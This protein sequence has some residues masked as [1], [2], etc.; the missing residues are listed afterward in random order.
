MTIHEITRVC[1]TDNMEGMRRILQDIS[2]KDLIELKR[3]NSFFSTV[4]IKKWLYSL[5]P[6]RV[7]RSE[8]RVKVDS[9]RDNM[10]NLI[11]WCWIEYNGWKYKCKNANIHLTEIRRLETRKDKLWRHEHRDDMQYYK[12]VSALHRRAF[13]KKRKISKF[14]RMSGNNY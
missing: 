2:K 8:K 5:K 13:K 6:D 3:S 4:H 1:A 9:R 7:V 12:I 11:N 14:N 10:A